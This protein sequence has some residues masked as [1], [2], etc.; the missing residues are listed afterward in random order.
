MGIPNG[1]VCVIL[2]WTLRLDWSVGDAVTSGFVIGSLRGS[3][4]GQRGAALLERVVARQHVC[5]RRLAG[6]RSNEVRFGRFLANP[7]VTIGRLIEGWGEQTA[8]AA[9][10]RHV[11]AVQDTSELNFATT[12]Q[13]RRG[14]GE[15]GKGVGR[16]VLLHGMLALDAED[17]TCLGLVAGKVWTRAGRLSIPHDRR[18]LQDKESER[19]LATAQAAKTVLA[20][21]AAVTVIADRES[22]IYAE[23]ATLPG[24]NFHLITR[25]MHDRA[26]A[27]GGTLY[28]ASERMRPADQ[29]VIKL[30]ARP[31]RPARDAKV[32][33][34]FGPVVLRRPQSRFLRDLPPSVALTLVEVAEPNPPPGS[35]PI[36]WRLL[37]THALA[38]AGAAWRIVNWYK[39]RWSIE[40]LFRVLKIQGLK[41][42]D[43]QLETADRLVKLAAIAAKAAAITIQLLQ[44]RNGHGSQPATLAFDPGQIE[45]LDALNAELEGKTKLQKNPHP[46]HAL[47]WAAWIIGRLGGWDGYP[48]SKPAGPITMKNGLEFFHAAAVGWGLKSVCMP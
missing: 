30:P 18:R 20:A 35:E 4:P 34:R 1:L 43:S 3:S 11:L 6:R 12:R 24:P 17:G 48:S 45:A 14:L 22:D 33:L 7:K 13:R 41:I 31:Q 37:T 46:K 9:C 21:A 29:A 28:A 26:L 39:A 10:G 2:F 40:Q 47:A 44:A 38:D 5:V 36:H 32:T 27:D 23:W 8:A 25:V 19:W 15:I 16:G 42:E